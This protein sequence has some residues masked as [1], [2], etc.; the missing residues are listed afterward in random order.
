MT[1]VE[2]TNKLDTLWE[3]KHF[4]FLKKCFIHYKNYYDGS[5]DSLTLQTDSIIVNGTTYT[6]EEIKAILLNYY[7][8]EDVNYSC[9][10]DVV[11][12]F[13]T[14]LVEDEFDVLGDL[15]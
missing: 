5:F 6:Q 7:I 14:D 13:F 2:L 1:K 8:D 3:K 15:E 9:F 11:Y 12:M 10:G 4:E